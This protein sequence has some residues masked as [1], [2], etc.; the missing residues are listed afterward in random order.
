MAQILLVVVTVSMA[1]TPLVAEA[2]K[3]I[4][5]A[6]EKYSLSRPENMMNF[7]ILCQGDLA[8]SWQ[9]MACLAGVYFV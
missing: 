5:L 2:G 1:L 8:G 9:L 4:A 3:K 6:L 7:T